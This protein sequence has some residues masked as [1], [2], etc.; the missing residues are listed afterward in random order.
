MLKKEG[1]HVILDYCTWKTQKGSFNCEKY[2]WH[3][4]NS[5]YELFTKYK[6]HIPFL[7]YV[8]IYC[9]NLNYYFS[10]SSSSNSQRL[11]GIIEDKV[12]VNSK[13]NNAHRSNESMVEQTLDTSIEGA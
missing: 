2:I 7:P 1:Q 12:P 9:C 13:M 3:S 11:M 5:F 10:I 6:L 4:I 8:F